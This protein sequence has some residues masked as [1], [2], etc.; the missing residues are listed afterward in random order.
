MIDFTMP[1]TPFHLG[2]ALILKPVAQRH[3]SLI[4][5]GMA[6]IA[7]DIEPLIGMMRNAEV[8]HGPTHTFLGAMLVA[9]PVALISPQICP[10]ILR[11]LNREAKTHKLG[12]LSEPEQAT[13]SVVWLSAYFGTLSHV[14]LDSF[15]HHD[16]RPFGPFSDANPL[17]NVLAHDAVYQLCWIFGIVGAA[18]WLSI[19]WL[20]HR[21]P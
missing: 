9:M 8:L 3:F 21:A 15:M 6:Q 16:I 18:A 14:V 1:F 10:P 2:A 12:W 5:F 19:K 13:R 7:M 11:R 4:T 17:L 20:R